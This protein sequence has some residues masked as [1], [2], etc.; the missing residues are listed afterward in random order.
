MQNPD[1]IRSNLEQA[2]KLVDFYREEYKSGAIHNANF[3]A[4]M[5][6]RISSISYQRITGMNMQQLIP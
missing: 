2:E 5:G 3:I 1:E 6:E 4:T